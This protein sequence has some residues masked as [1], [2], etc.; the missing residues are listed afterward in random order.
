MVTIEDMYLKSCNITSDICEHVKVHRKLSEECDSVVEIGVRS[1]V[2]TWG[3]LMGLKPGSTYIGIDLDQPPFETFN[4]AKKLAEEKG[5]SS[6][7]PIATIATI[8]DQRYWAQKAKTMNK[9]TLETFVREIR[10]QESQTQTISI[11]KKIA[12]ELEKLS[13]GN[14]NK[15]LTEL[16]QLKKEQL[17]KP[18]TTQTKSRHIPQKIKNYIKQRSN[19]KCEFPNCTKPFKHFHHT[20]RFAS[21]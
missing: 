13:N 10:N 6:I 20:K 19:N 21:F 2:S 3:I 8:K 12:T 1:M 18:E 16:I 15:L 9:N 17:Q 7:R 11:D 14:I 5:L 4:L